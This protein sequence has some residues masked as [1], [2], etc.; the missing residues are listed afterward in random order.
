[1]AA[2][3]PAM[4][5]QPFTCDVCDATY[6]EAFFRPGGLA[7]H[8]LKHPGRNLLACNQGRASSAVPN[9]RMTHWRTHTGEM[10]VACAVC[11]K[12]F[13]QLAHV[14]VHRRRRAS[15]KPVACTVSRASFTQ[16]GLAVRCT[17]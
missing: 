10:P 2:K 8:K 11:P 16:P 14:L 12:T 3:H 9:R 4:G 17:R 5:E 6:S 13:A 15:E 1:M 7:S